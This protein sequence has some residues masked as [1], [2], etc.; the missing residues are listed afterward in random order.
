M[1]MPSQLQPEEILF[2]SD[3][4]KEV[5]AA[6]EAKMRSILVDRPGNAPV[7]DEDRKRLDVVDSLSE[8]N[9]ATP[10]AKSK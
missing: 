2:L 1:L 5:D 10:T 8:I 7:S 3:N 6:T 9:V 4:V